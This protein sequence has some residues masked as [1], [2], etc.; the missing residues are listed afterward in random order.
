MPKVDKT[1][2]AAAAVKLPSQNDPVWRA[3]YSAENERMKEEH[4]GWKGPYR[5][6]QIKALWRAQHAD[7]ADAAKATPAKKKAAAKKDAVVA[8]NAEGHNDEGGGSGSE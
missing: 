4:P 3:F 5:K 1:K 6:K 8:P 2:K 7:D